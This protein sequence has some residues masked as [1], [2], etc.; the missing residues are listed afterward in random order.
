MTSL[1]Y[2]GSS[3][4]VK[5]LLYDSKL[6]IF[7]ESLGQGGMAL[8]CN[9]ACKHPSDIGKCEL[10]GSEKVSLTCVQGDKAPTAH[11][12][13]TKLLPNGRFH[14]QTTSSHLLLVSSSLVHLLASIEGDFRVSSWVC[15]IQPLVY[16][17]LLLLKPDLTS[18][19]TSFS[20][21][22]RILHLGVLVVV[23]HPLLEM[24]QILWRVWSPAQLIMDTII[25]FFSEVKEKQLAL[26]Q[27]YLIPLPR[28]LSYYLLPWTQLPKEPL[29][30]T[31]TFDTSLPVLPIPLPPPLLSAQSFCSYFYTS[32]TNLYLLD[33]HSLRLSMLPR[34]TSLVI[35]SRQRGDFVTPADTNLEVDGEIFIR[36]TDTGV[37]IIIKDD[38]LWYR[39]LRPYTY[40]GDH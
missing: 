13:I 31:P 9:L 4:K 24:P 21:I 10:Q 25:Y 5:V 20:R 16:H 12:E 7:Q 2:E 14:F 6:H 8:M 17:H 28:L 39:M 15:R 40:R 36:A 27:S 11:S 3:S 18:V 19:T 32:S 38:P 35:P 26:A 29:P 30:P 34:L 23:W 22:A 1:F 37:D 33:L